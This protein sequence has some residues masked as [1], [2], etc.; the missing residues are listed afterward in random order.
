MSLRCQKC[1][2]PIKYGYSK[3]Q[4]LSCGWSATKKN[5]DIEL[6]VSDPMW[7]EPETTALPEPL[8]EGYRRVRR[9][10]ESGEPYLVCALSLE[11]Y[12]G[13]AVC[14]PVLMGAAL[15]QTTHPS[16]A[17]PIT[18]ERS[19]SLWMETLEN[20]LTHE[21]IRGVPAVEW[22]LSETLTLA[23][24]AKAHPFLPDGVLSAKPDPTLKKNLLHMLEQLKIDSAGAYADIK[25]SF[26]KNK[27][28]LEFSVQNSKKYA[29]TGAAC[30]EGQVYLPSHLS[31]KGTLT[32]CGLSDG[33]Y[34][35]LPLPKGFSPVSG[36][37]GMCAALSALPPNPTL[38]TH[39]QNEL[40]KDFKKGVLLVHTETEMGVPSGG[41]GNE[42]QPLVIVC[43]MRRSGINGGVHALFERVAASAK[44]D[45]KMIRRID[46][47]NRDAMALLLNALRAEHP[48][49]VLLFVAN[50]EAFEDF[51]LSPEKL[52]PLESQLSE[53]VW[54]ALQTCASS[55]SCTAGRKMKIGA[56]D[57][58]HKAFLTEF[59]EK[60]CPLRLLQ[61][62]AKRAAE[63]EKLVDATEGQYARAVL[64]G[65]FGRFARQ[66]DRSDMLHTAAEEIFLTMARELYGVSYDDFVRVLFLCWTAEV[67]CESGDVVRFYPDMN[68]SI[69]RIVLKDAAQ[70]TEYHMRSLLA[71]S[72]P[73]MEALCDAYIQAA[74]PQDGFRRIT[75]AAYAVARFGNEKQKNTLHSK[76]MQEAL[77]S[78]A[79]SVTDSVS[80]S[81]RRKL[82]EAAIGTQKTAAALGGIKR[83]LLRIYEQSGS[84][85][86]ALCL[87]KELHKPIEAGKQ[88]GF[89][90]MEGSISYA[91]RLMETEDHD[92]AL[93][94]LSEAIQ[95]QKDAETDVDAQEKSLLFFRAHA[96]C[97]ALHLKNQNP[98]RAAEEFEAA[99]AHLQKADG[100]VDVFHRAVA[101]DAHGL[102]GALLQSQ[103]NDGEAVKH[104]SALADLLEQEGGDREKRMEAHRN[105]AACHT[106]LLQDDEALAA[107]AKA[108]TLLLENK[109]NR[110]AGLLTE[111]Y[112]RKAELF[113]KK[114]NAEAALE[115]RMKVVTC[116]KKR[117][118]AGEKNGISLCTALQK[119][120][121]NALR[122]GK[123][124]RAVSYLDI[125]TE[126][127]EKMTAAG[128][129]TDSDWLGEVY[130]QRADALAAAG[131][132]KKAAGETQKAAALPASA[133][134]E[135]RTAKQLKNAGVSLKCREYDAAI[136]G[137]RP[138]LKKIEKFSEE[139]AIEALR[140]MAFACLG[141]QR[142]AEAMPH[143]ETIVHR[144]ETS[145]ARERHTDVLA[146]ATLSMGVLY[147]RQGEEEPAL[148]AYNTG[149]GLCEERQRNRQY[150]D[151][152][153]VAG[154][155][156]SRALLY[157][158][159]AEYGS[160]ID[161]LKRAVALCKETEQPDLNALARLYLNLAYVYAQSEELQS[162]LQYNRKVVDLRE[163]LYQDGKASRA[164]LA[165]AYMNLAILL[166]GDQRVSEEIRCYGQGIALLERDQSAKTEETRLLVKLY[167]YR[168]MSY[169][170]L[171]RQEAQKKDL[172]CADALEI[173]LKM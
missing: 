104:F 33:R 88:D 170:V 42:G 74:N 167:R 21:E 63:I 107:Y 71:D 113:E 56:Q 82:Y 87:A 123:A 169:E 64:I 62:P 15:L 146:Y 157:A 137:V 143:L 133:D 30:Q 141:A 124:N 43:D 135:D 154:A 102:Y 26:S 9:T 163:R 78:A 27:K 28:T 8:K 5:A 151:T 72:K 93:T 115:E 120:A 131:H 145:P 19:L 132:F 125:V 45:P 149:I 69:V 6:S 25:V 11:E 89:S 37:E 173:S 53:G 130:R 16:F 46:G 67:P 95:T 57:E 147:R 51:S 110:A 31:E 68:P 70:L 7:F 12:I 22:L 108:E 162:A 24:Q 172:Q 171:G 105:T 10:L 150:V 52:L 158:D 58:Q 18:E 50:A 164:E 1:H 101:C 20:M 66:P 94:V 140:I 161:D 34:L 117:Y 116:L 97:G 65:A 39:V 139:N 109:T 99:F 55:F 122:C 14:L 35:T 165:R 47:M 166:G 38:L 85:F 75:N 29:L 83:A 23:K 60:E 40:K 152:N 156:S 13:Q 77:S 91:A 59:L 106:A 112:E 4:C 79:E 80:E 155:Y 114:Q 100:H 142:L 3:Q 84:H 126:L 92:R 160:A 90:V 159:R 119:A 111:I 98:D 41:F 17:I 48:D 129:V 138:L 61:T 136:E 32:F 118:D 144:I 121:E 134:G 128:L 127:A 148:K 103:K 153:R 49:G 96:L 54:I 73:L 81:D 2:A 86:L 44:L 36:S 168:A 76:G